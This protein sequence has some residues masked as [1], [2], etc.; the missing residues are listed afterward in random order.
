MASKTQPAK[1]KTQN[2]NLLGVATDLLDS[3]GNIDLPKNADLKE[4]HRLFRLLSENDSA[5]RVFD[6][7]DGETRWLQGAILNHLFPIEKGKKG[8]L[9]KGE[10]KVFREDF[11]IGEDTSMNLR[12][13]HRRFDRLEARQLGYT[14]MVN[15]YRDERRLEKDAQGKGKGN[16]KGN[17]KSGKGKGGKTPR[18]LRV[19][20]LKPKVE[21]ITGSLEFLRDE[22]LTITDF[23]KDADKSKSVLVELLTRVDGIRETTNGL[24]ASIKKAY[25]T[26]QAFID[27]GHKIAQGERL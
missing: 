25:E 16:G 5:L 13:I 23:T 22:I 15:Q 4:C 19:D 10:Y 12:H 26:V 8:I 24:E 1:S 3:I 14:K 18:S 6:K 17:G 20:D 9:K 7:C 2:P 27:Q 11:E 21:R